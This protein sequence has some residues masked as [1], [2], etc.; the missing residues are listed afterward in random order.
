M[1]YSMAMVENFKEAFSLFDKDNKSVIDVAN[2]GRV[3]RAIGL[4]PSDDELKNMITEVDGSGK[5]AVDFAEFMKM[6][7]KNGTETAKEVKETFALFNKSG[8]GSISKSELQEIM[9]ALGEKF[10]DKDLDDMI[11][12]IDKSGSGAV[13][14]ADFEACIVGEE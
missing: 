1:A 8:S 10:D 13:S 2:L 6:M 12:S 7:S 9:S 4:E 5:N 14:F 3:M 11:S